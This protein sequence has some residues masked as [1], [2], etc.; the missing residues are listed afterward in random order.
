M[1]CYLSMINI[2]LPSVGV[3]KTD[4]SLT[5][6]PFVEND[7]VGANDLENSRQETVESKAEKWKKDK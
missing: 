4:N 6:K 3:Y 7:T 2:W 1:F 5:L